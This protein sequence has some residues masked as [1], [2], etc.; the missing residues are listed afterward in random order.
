MEEWIQYLNCEQDTTITRMRNVNG[1]SD[2]FGVYY[3]GIG[4][5]N[6]GCGGHMS[7]EFYAEEYKRY[8]TYLT[9]V[10]N[11]VLFRIASG[12][13][14]DDFNWTEKFMGIISGIL[15][16][17][18]NHLALVNGFAI[19]YYCGTAGSAT[20]YSIDEWYQLFYQAIRIE[21]L[22]IEHRNI[23][24]KYDPRHLVGLIVDEWGTWHHPDPEFKGKALFQQNTIRDALVAAITLNIFNNH[25]DTVIMAN[26]AQVI[27]VLQALILTD[28]PKMLLTPTYHVFDL[29][30]PHQNGKA[31]SCEIESP[32]IS[33]QKQAES[34]TIPQVSVS[35][36]QKGDYLTLSLV[37]L[38]ATD[39]MECELVFNGCK[40]LEFQS[41]SELSSPD[42]H[43][44]NTFEKS[45]KVKPIKHD[46]VDQTLLKL[47][48]NPAS[49]NLLE[50]KIIK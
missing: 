13:N 30:Q 32:V 44:H 43:D 46:V 16:G 2:P 47:K 49:I 48:C 45:D 7:P 42:I 9:P 15:N 5:E 50:Y 39:G 24:N 38:H 20:K 19:H 21:S 35:C 28:G 23:M 34:L 40:E 25:A 8:A 31:L 14:S 41:W 11:R 36:S 10:Q 26:I 1:Q 37:N 33:F 3:F 6:W 4:N 27:N 18:M 29:Y 22:I 17:S 12:S